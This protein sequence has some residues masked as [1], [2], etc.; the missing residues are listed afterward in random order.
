MPQ[1]L[2]PV[3]ESGKLAVIPTETVYGLAAPVG[4]PALIERVFQLKE[5][6]L[7]NPLIVHISDP[8]QIEVYAM[9]IPDVAYE[10]AAMFWPGPM[11]LVLPKKDMVP[12][13]VTAGKP[14]VALRVPNHPLT[15]DLLKQFG[16]A[17]VA[18]SANKFT[19]VSPT[20]VRAA[21][22][23]FSESD[24]T[25]F[26]G[27]HCGVGIES[28]ILKPDPNS[29]TLFVLRRGMLDLEKVKGVA[30][31]AGWKMAVDATSETPEAPGQLKVHYRPKSPLFV[32]PK[33]CDFDLGL[34]NG[35]LVDMGF[36]SVTELRYLD[37][38]DESYLAARQLYA[39]ME[40]LSS[41]ESALV[42]VYDHQQHSG[43]GW[44]AILDR[45]GRAALR[46]QMIP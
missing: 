41:D 2:K 17:V 18:P 6:P 32:F 8:S 29:K 16:G 30:E 27:G 1:D 13:L 20:S 14:T 19:Q 28:T 33:G 12:D 5:R 44:E 36:S 45:L 26:D 15:I 46:F 9:D 35:Y 42:F 40:E 3:F 22:Q 31:A 24:V 4:D 38:S 10:L 37:L 21:K 23:W 11:T 34:V 25:F 43:S 7:F 39:A